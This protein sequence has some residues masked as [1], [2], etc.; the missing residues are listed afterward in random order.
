MQFKSTVPFREKERWEARAKQA[1]EQ[2]TTS[3]S[4]DVP[5][6]RGMAHPISNTASTTGNDAQSTGSS[7]T[8]QPGRTVPCAADSSVQ[9]ET[10]EAPSHHGLPLISA[11][12]GQGDLED[13]ALE[14]AG[15]S[16]TAAAIAAAAAACGASA[17]GA[18][19]PAVSGRARHVYCEE[20]IPLALSNAGL[21]NLKTQV[22]LG[23]LPNC[24]QFVG[25]CFCLRAWGKREKSF[26]LVF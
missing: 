24:E 14:K 1:A 22:R 7:C 15:S 23:N 8:L 3:S 26:S 18:A 25:D 4:S 17:A 19:A 21:P 6:A 2:Q 10:G 9:P 13:L 12:K 16:A 11:I 20:A 5:V